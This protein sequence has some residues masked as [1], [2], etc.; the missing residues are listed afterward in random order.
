MK[1]RVTFARSS[2]K[3]FVLM[4]LFSAGVAAITLHRFYHSGVSRSGAERVPGEDSLPKIPLPVSK[5]VRNST[6]PSSLTD[7]E[8]WID[9]LSRDSKDNI[10][11]AALDHSP[12][13][14]MLFRMLLISNHYGNS[15]QGELLL[16]TLQ[17]AYGNSF[18]ENPDASARVLEDGLRELPIENFALERGAL[19]GTLATLP[20]YT[21]Q[22]RERSL[23]EMIH[24]TPP[25][26]MVIR[27]DMSEEQKNIILSTDDPSY[28]SPVLAHSYFLETSHDFQ[29]SFQGTLKALEVQKDLGVRNAIVN[30]LLEKYPDHQNEIQAQ[31]LGRTVAKDVTGA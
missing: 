11:Q 26:R 28:Q 14:K 23:D 1:N 3:V 18:L 16:E 21:E 9:G 19:I 12:Q 24:S 13:G 10:L 4:I 25:E 30:Q 27:P 2:K 15:P 22:A 20:G 31:L 29:D 7:V 5:V 6:I 17:K 8:I